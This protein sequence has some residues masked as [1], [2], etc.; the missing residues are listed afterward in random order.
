MRIIVNSKICTGCRS[1]ELACSFKQK[2]SFQYKFSLIC[3]FKNEEMEGFYKPILCLHCKE[4][5]CADGC[6]TDA[7]KRDTNSG[8]VVIDRDLCTACG[9]CVNL[10]PWSAPILDEEEG[11]A[12][13]CNLCQGD[14]LCVQ[15]CATGALVLE[16]E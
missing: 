15:F 5:Y 14:P 3:I 4:M 10:C 2:N 7:I 16:Q 1:C 11:I 13:I 9:S 12:K 8:L 6:P